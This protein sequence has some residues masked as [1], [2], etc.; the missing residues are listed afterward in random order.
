MATMA[1]IVKKNRQFFAGWKT[2][3]SD[4]KSIDLSAKNIHL[5]EIIDFMIW[6]SK[7][8]KKHEK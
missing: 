2:F 4:Q 5:T 6:S 8:P 3:V 1:D 7:L